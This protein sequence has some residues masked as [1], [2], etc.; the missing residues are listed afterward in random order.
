MGLSAMVRRV[1]L[2]IE[3]LPPCEE[4]RDRIPVSLVRK[5]ARR[6]RSDDGEECS[7]EQYRRLALHGECGRL[8]TISVIVEWDGE[9]I[10]RGLL[11]REKPSSQ[12]HFDEARTLRGF[13]KLVK[14]FNPGR[15]L[16][17]GHNVMQFDLPFLYKR[18]MINRVQ[19]TVEVSLARYR[20]QSVFD[21]MQVWS[22][23]DS[24][25]YLS[26]SEL[27]GLLGLGGKAE[28]MNGGCV[29]DYICRGEHDRVARYALQDVE[30]VRAIYYRM[31]YPEFFIPGWL[32]EEK[33]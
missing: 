23:W 5:L 6:R 13:W 2:D 19:P 29:Y 26:L 4:Q 31:A 7:E 24:R 33:P 18:S 20:R 1:F 14:D 32:P 9:I 17:V 21:T 11:G 10:H 28:G 30:L 8:L 27:G 22:G 16:F 3:T 25:Y 12:F 15:D